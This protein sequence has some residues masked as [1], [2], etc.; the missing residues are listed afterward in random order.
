LAKYLF[1]YYILQIQELLESY[2]ETQLE[3]VF[4]EEFSSFENVDWHNFWCFQKREGENDF[5][6]Q[7]ET[8][9]H[10]EKN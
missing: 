7:L 9:F 6:T 8:F 5:E 4:Y 10:K 2:F 3:A 1:F